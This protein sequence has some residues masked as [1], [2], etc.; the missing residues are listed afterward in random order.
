VGSERKVHLDINPKNTTG[1]EIPSRYDP[2]RD[3]SAEADKLMEINGQ[4]AI[5]ME[6]TERILDDLDL[7]D[8]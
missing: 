5:D 3:P 4:R 8:L 1:T 6:T 2:N 7:S